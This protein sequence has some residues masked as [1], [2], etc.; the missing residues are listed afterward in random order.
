MMAVACSI[1]KKIDQINFRQLDHSVRKAQKVVRVDRYTIILME[2]GSVATSPPLGNY[3]YARGRWSW[4][5]SVLRGLVRLGVLDKE[6]VEK[7]LADCDRVSE[8]SDRRRAR[9]TVE[10]I[11]KKYGA[12]VSQKA[13]SRIAKQ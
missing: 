12:K 1:V 6:D 10:R 13:L 4:Q 2:D 8:E 3:A 11:A 9:E 5:P 7:H